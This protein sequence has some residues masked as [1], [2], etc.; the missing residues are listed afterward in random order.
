[1]TARVGG[2]TVMPSS[3]LMGIAR[4]GGKTVMPSR[5]LMGIAWVGHKTVMPS[6]C[7]MGIEF[8]EILRHRIEA[9]RAIKCNW[10]RTIVRLYAGQS[11]LWFEI[12]CM[13]KKIF[14]DLI[15]FVFHPVFRLL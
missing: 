3:C 8:A 13:V 10:R 11:K 15:I 7:L 9:R 6:R 12:N 4:V 1:M 2:K 14:R 5:C